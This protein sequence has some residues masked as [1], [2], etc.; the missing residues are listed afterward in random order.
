MQALRED[1]LNI[2]VGDDQ[3]FFKRLAARDNVAGFV[4]HQ[5]VAVKDQFI[6][7]AYKIA[8]DQR[9]SI[10]FGARAEHAFAVLVLACMKWR[11]RDVDDQVRIAAERLQFRW[12]AR[13]PD[14]FAD[15]DAD[16]R[17]A[18]MLNEARMMARIDAPQVVRAID[19]GVFDGVGYVVQEYVVLTMYVTNDCAR[20]SDPR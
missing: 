2:D 19:A 18:R 8:I 13:I 9:H 6:L 14:V 5:T 12:P 10:I 1:A 11:G 7:P 4:D 20:S 17:F 3:V 16:A 15:V